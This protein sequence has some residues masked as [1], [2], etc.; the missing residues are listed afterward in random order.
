MKKRIL[1]FMVIMSVSLCGCSF[2]EKNEEHKN[3]AEAEQNEII[4]DAEKPERNETAENITDESGKNETTVQKALLYG[5]IGEL[6]TG[7]L[8]YAIS[9]QEGEDYRL[10]FLEAEDSYEA[11]SE[12][13]INLE[14]ADYIFPDVR[15]G[16]AAIGKFSDIYFWDM[17]DMTGDDRAE[18][19]AIAIYERDGNK[20]FDT[21]VYEIIENGIRANYDLIQELNEKYSSAEYYP[22]EEI[23]TLPHD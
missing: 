13:D 8:V 7:Y 9:G 3:T 1:I 23:V 11:L 19:L 16:N 18:L 5:G 4:N 10:Y 14:E 15:E 22:V 6:G 21:R 17:A 12:A 2:N 20:Y